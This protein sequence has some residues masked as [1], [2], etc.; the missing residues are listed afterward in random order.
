MKVVFLTL[1]LITS[2]ALACISTPIYIDVDKAQKS[3]EAIG[4]SVI[5][6][7]IHKIEFPKVEDLI[8]KEVKLLNF[9][10]GFQYEAYTRPGLTKEFSFKIKTDKEIIVSLMIP[11]LQRGG[12]DDKHGVIYK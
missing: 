1:S 11:P 7:S 9:S 2:N 12:C 5:F 10:G 6:K 4:R 3:I 8:F